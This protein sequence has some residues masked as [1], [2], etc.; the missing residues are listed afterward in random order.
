M[1]GA[2]NRSSKTRTRSKKEKQKQEIEHLPQHT[3]MS[4]NEGNELPNLPSGQQT[5]S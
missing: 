5:Q 1:N 2:V 3:R 4:L